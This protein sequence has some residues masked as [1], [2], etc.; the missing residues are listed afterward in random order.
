MTAIMALGECTCLSPT[1]Q[2][3]VTMHNESVY[4]HVLSSLSMQSLSNSS[5]K[6]VSC[7]KAL[8]RAEQVSADRLCPLRSS[9]ELWVVLLS[10]SWIATLSWGSTPLSLHSRRYVCLKVSIV[11]QQ[12]P[13]DE[14]QRIFLVTKTQWIKKAQSKINFCFNA[15][16]LI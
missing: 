2:H 7:C 8:A 14:P 10:W 1:E 9:L 4:A 12:D 6:T 11:G 13:Y 3:V 5:V 15:E 16:L